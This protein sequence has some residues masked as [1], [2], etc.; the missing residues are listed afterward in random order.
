M[1]WIYEMLLE[2]IDGK[3]NFKENLPDVVVIFVPYGLMH[4]GLVLP[5]GDTDLDQYWFR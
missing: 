1:L 5:Y 4:C 3:R 2:I